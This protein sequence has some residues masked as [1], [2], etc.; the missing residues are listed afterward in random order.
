MRDNAQVMMQSLDARAQKVTSM[1]AVDSMTSYAQLAEQHAQDLGKLAAAFQ[2]LYASFPDDQKKQ[3]DEF[4]RRQA[5]EHMAQHGSH[6]K[7]G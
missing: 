3:A 6:H 4:F 1:D 2:T 5:T 7:E